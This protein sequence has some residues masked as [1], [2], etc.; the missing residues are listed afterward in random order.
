M[1]NNIVYE[2]I[3]QTTFTVSARAKVLP[4]IEPYLSTLVQPGDEVLDLCCGSGFVSFWFEA[5]AAK[6]TGMDLAP[7]MIALA[8]EEAN[9]RRS[10]VEFIEADIF[11]RDFGQ[12]RFD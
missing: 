8:K 2:W 3:L 11:A 4:R 10:T 12:E 7:Y 6:V 1:N 9:R 5:Q